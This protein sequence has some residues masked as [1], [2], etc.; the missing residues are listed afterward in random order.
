M[1]ATDAKA[2]EE[3]NRPPNTQIKISYDTDRTRLHAKTYV[4]YRDT[5][6]T[7]AYV[8]SSNLSKVAMSSGLE[9]NVKVTAKDLPT[10]L[11]KIT[12][13]F[14]SYWNAP[15]FERYQEGEHDRLLRALKA[16]QG[17]GKDQP[18]D[19]LFNI[20]PY[21]YQQEILD[22][23]DAE[24]KVC[25]LT[26]N[27]VVAATGTGKT[28]SRPLIIGV[29]A[30]STLAVRTAYCLWPTERKFSDKASTHSRTFFGTLTLVTSLWAA[31]VRRA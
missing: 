23:L 10:T 6:F 30:R 1:G 24:R 16:E 25:G 20:R 29:F 12:A 3:L 31:A 21:S 8:G 27:L 22:K 11:N 26:R 14:D 13:T 17:K 4:F 9:W 15:E 2:I 5:G 7:T 28:A 18:R 19:M